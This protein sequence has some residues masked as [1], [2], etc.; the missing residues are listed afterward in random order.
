MRHVLIVH[1]IYTD[2]P[3]VSDRVMGS[4]VS[5]T[6][7]DLKAVKASVPALAHLGRVRRASANLL[8]RVDVEAARVTVPAERG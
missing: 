8:V 2:R 5:S 4:L 3:V 1:L 6:S 7:R